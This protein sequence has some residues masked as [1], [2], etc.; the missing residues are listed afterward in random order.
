MSSTRITGKKQNLYKGS[1]F[2]YDVTNDCLNVSW[3]VSLVLYARFLRGFLCGKKRKE[4][5]IAH[6]H[7]RTVF[8][9]P[10]QRGK[11]TFLSLIIFE[12]LLVLGLFC[13]LCAPATKWRPFSV[14][15]TV[16]PGESF[17]S[18]TASWHAR[19]QVLIISFL[20]FFFAQQLILHTKKSIV[21]L[22]FFFISSFLSSA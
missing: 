5:M 22:I 19:T 20:F 12:S 17:H 18:E 21:W 1:T 2:L 11:R 4:R 6:I 16:Y 13:V 9:F 7:R 15:S 10:L 14:Q 8:L 3:W